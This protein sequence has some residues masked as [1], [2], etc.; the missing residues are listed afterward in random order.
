MNKCKKYHTKTKQLPFDLFFEINY[1]KLHRPSTL[2][3]KN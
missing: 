2:L 3:E 1:H